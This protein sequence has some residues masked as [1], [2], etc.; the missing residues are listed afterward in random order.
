[1]KKIL[2]LMAVI[3]ALS[4]AG[5]SKDEGGSDGGGNVQN[6]INAI[7]DKSTAKNLVIS[8]ELSQNDWEILK[9]VRKQLPLIENITLSDVRTIE[10]GVFVYKDGIYYISN[11]W[12]KSISAPKVEKVGKS[13]F[14]SC[15]ELVSVNFPNLKIAEEEAFSAC[16]KLGAIEFQHLTTIGERAFAGCSALQSIKFGASTEIKTIATSF[17]GLDAQTINLS[18]GDYEISQ[19]VGKIWKDK[20]WKSISNNDGIAIPDP[21]FGV[22]NF[23]C[24]KD[25]VIQH[26][27]GT[28]VSGGIIYEGSQGS[29]WWYIY[30]FDVNE[31][32]ISGTTDYS[33]QFAATPTDWVFLPIRQYVDELNKLK[34]KFGNPTYA[35]EDVF[36]FNMTDKTYQPGY[37][38]YESQAVMNGGKSFTYK[39]SNNT[40][41][42]ESVLSF[43]LRSNKYQTWGF[44]IRTTYSKK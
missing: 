8:G 41:D 38:W 12:L 35:S 31:T 39:F 10:F 36:S 28:P 18:L 44:T 20:T 15:E 26:E 14:W 30:D 3:A 29:A 4:F 40:T 16:E 1:M 32:F 37:S 27:K 17:D 5:C 6:A 23:G 42:V 13:A 33:F 2:L 9:N 34:N 43:Y 21:D 19:A 24:T 11:N 22:A 25:F 7:Q